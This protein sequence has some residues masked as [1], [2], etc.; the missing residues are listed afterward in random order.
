MPV[1]T[2]LD[3]TAAPARPDASPRAAIAAGRARAIAARTDSFRHIGLDSL[4]TT[5]GSL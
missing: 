2:S 1:P 5:A 4:L 3:G